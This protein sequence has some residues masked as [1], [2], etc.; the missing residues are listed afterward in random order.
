ML[1]RWDPWYAGGTSKPNYGPTDTYRIAAE[2]LRGLSVEDWGCGYARFR[3]F[4]D[5]PYVG[6]DGT[7]GWA[8]VIADLR[9][10]R[11]QTDGLL[12][13]HVLEHNVDW[14]LILQNAAHSFRRRLAL[15]LFTPD[16]G[17]TERQLDFVAAVNVP[18]L[19]LPFA[20]IERALGGCAITRRHVPTATGY[21]GETVFLVEKQAGHG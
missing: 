21:Q 12:L 18:D 15:V 7:R 4:H 6:V 2:W 5:G 11:S 13:R 8:A 20:D 19:A 16:S 10:Y 14:R 1:G 17:E 9:H 3:E